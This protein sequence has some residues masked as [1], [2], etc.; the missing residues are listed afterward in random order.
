MLYPGRF[1]L[2]ESVYLWPYSQKP[3]Q[4]AFPV[5]KEANIIEVKAVKHYV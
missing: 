4:K 1:I 3:F 2:I 5:K